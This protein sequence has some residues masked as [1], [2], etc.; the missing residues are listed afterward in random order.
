M[1]NWVLDLPNA[2]R[3]SDGTWTKKV[4]IAE[5][6]GDDEDILVDQEREQGGTGVLLVS[7]PERITR[8]LARCTVR[9]GTEG[10]P[11]GRT[12][13]DETDHFEDHWRKAISADRVFTLIRL[14]Q[15]SLGNVYS[16][17]I[18]CP[19]CGKEIKN[20]RTDLDKL[21]VVS[22]PIAFVK[23]GAHDTTLPRSGDTVAWRPLSGIDEEPVEK[24]T[25]ERKSDYMSAIMY[26][27]I[28]HVTPPGGAPGKPEGGLVYVKRMKAMDRRFFGTF[29]DAHEG[30]IDTDITVSCDECKRDSTTKLRVMGSDFFFPSEVESIGNSTSVRQPKPGE[31]LQENGEEYLSDD[32]SA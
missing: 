11:E 16:T 28:V 14:R 3:Q 23:E 15:M 27:R 25:R 2:I 5:M 20:V 4:E 32:A 7:G 19:H 6:E 8:I 26:R 17:T 22:M 24:I 13:Y 9:I 10:R 1:S 29:I 12:R 18:T 31:S 30:G 21:K